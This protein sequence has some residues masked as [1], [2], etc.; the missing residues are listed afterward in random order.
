[1]MNFSLFLER[2]E[3]N[4]DLKMTVERLAMTHGP[5]AVLHNLKFCKLFVE[6]FSEEY[7]QFC[8]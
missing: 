3:A 6:R 7:G 8:K 2:L 1:M 4:R 5:D